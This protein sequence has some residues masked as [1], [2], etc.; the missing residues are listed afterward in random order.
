MKQTKNLIAAID[1]CVQ[2]CFKVMAAK[3]TWLK[4][5]WIIA[6]LNM[7]MLAKVGKSLIYCYFM[8]FYLTSIL[9]N[10]ENALERI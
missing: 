1:V 4:F 5:L 6:S 2:T 7:W 9:F 3:V 8:Q 10:K